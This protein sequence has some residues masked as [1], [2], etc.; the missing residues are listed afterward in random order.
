MAWITLLTLALVSTT[1]KCGV[2]SS[3]LVALGVGGCFLPI[4]PLPPDPA[5]HSPTSSRL[6]G[7]RRPPQRHSSAPAPHLHP[8]TPAALPCEPLLSLRT[9]FLRTDRPRRSDPRD[10]L[11]LPTAP[12]SDHAYPPGARRPRRRTAPV[13]RLVPATRICARLGTLLHRMSASPPSWSR[14]VDCL[15]PPIFA[16]LQCWRRSLRSSLPRELTAG[17]GMQSTSSTSLLILILSR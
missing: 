16:R 9:T 2:F 3:T 12:P 15:L 1:N 10:R 4:Q 7:P 13:A 5:S 11:R 6:G 17:K 8:R 14:S